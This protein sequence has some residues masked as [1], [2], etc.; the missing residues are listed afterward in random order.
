MYKTKVEIAEGIHDDVLKRIV[1][2]EID[3]FFVD[4]EVNKAKHDSKEKMEWISRQTKLKQSLEIDKKLLVIIERKVSTYK[5]E[6]GLRVS[7]PKKKGT[8]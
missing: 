7:N 3:S 8:L 2:N 6:E 4:G 1:I 5:Y